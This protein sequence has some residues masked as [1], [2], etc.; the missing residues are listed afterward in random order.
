MKKY[1]NIIKDVLEQH[2]QSRDCD[3]S[4]IYRTYS[5]IEDLCAYDSFK[6]VLLKIREKKLPSFDTISRLG[7]LIK[8]ENPELRGS[9]YLDRMN[10]KQAKARKD[11]DYE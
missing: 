4:L 3:L 7:R 2:P 8:K 10:F 1:Q 5:E 9:D 6:S 11:L